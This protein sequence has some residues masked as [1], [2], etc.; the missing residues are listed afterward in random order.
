MSV[1]LIVN[2]VNVY[3]YLWLAEQQSLNASCTWDGECVD[4]HTSCLAVDPSKQESKFACLCTYLYI[5]V[6]GI[7][8]PGKSMIMLDMH[9][10]KHIDKEHFLWLTLTS[11]LMTHRQTMPA[12]QCHFSMESFYSYYN[13]KYIM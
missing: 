9:K 5:E 6:D 8:Q 7:C 3:I 1:E 10:R 12:E 11:K 13:I 4:N 2:S